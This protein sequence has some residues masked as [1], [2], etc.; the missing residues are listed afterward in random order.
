MKS[1]AF[2]IFTDLDG[3]YNPIGMGFFVCTCT[4]S[5]NKSI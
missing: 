4:T 3:T 1:D 2:V 5:N